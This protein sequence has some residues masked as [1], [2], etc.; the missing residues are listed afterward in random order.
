M[1]DRTT[2]LQYYNSYLKGKRLSDNLSNINTT[3]RFFYHLLGLDLTQK[4]SLLVKGE[5]VHET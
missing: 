3:Y 2:A 1:Y 5:K 4:I